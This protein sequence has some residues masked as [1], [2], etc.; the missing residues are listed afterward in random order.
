MLQHSKAPPQLCWRKHTLT[1]E[2]MH[3]STPILTPYIHT[4][5]VRWAP[6]IWN[7]SLPNGSGGSE[8]EGERL[9]LISPVEIAPGRATE[10]PPPHCSLQTSERGR[11]SSPYMS[12]SESM[13]LAASKLWYQ[14]SPGSLCLKN[15]PADLDSGD[16]GREKKERGWKDRKH[17]RTRVL[18]GNK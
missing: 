13:P 1:N 11:P 4:Y 15:A 14:N 17:R 5:I 16:R 9:R 8:L 10:C 3:V 6:T 12:T 7:V 18:L 2:C